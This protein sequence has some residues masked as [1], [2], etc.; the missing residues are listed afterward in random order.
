MEQRHDGDGDSDAARNEN[1]TPDPDAV[2]AMEAM[3]SKP[4]N[5]N[6]PP[7]VLYSTLEECQKIAMMNKNPWSELQVMRKAVDLLR[8]SGIF[9]DKVFEEWKDV[10][11]KSYVLMKDHSSTRRI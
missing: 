5:P 3:F 6:D 8:R 2:A 11:T 9:K 4:H 10:P 1:G 7:E